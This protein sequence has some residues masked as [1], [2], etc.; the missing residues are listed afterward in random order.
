MS[1]LYYWSQH[2]LWYD[3]SIH[4]DMISAYIMIWSQHTL[5]YDL[6]IHYDMISAYIMIWSQLTLWYDLSIHY[7]MISAYIMIWS[8]LTLWYDL[9]LHYDMISAYIMIW[10]QHTLWYDLSI[11]YDMISAY[12]MIWSQ[13]TLWYDLSI[14]YDMIPAYIMIWYIYR[15]GFIRQVDPRG[16]SYDGSPSRRISW[17]GR[18]SLPCYGYD[19]WGRHLASLEKLVPYGR[20]R[21]RSIQFQLR[22]GWSQTRDHPLIQVN[23][24]QG[25]RDYIIWWR[26]LRNLHKGIP[27]GSP[28]SKLSYSQTQ[29]LWVGVHTWPKGP[30]QGGGPRPWKI[31]TSMC[32]NWMRF[33]LVSKP[34]RIHSKTLML[35]LCATMSLPL[36]IWGIRGHSVSTDVPH[37]H[38]YLRMGWKTVHETDTQTSPWA[39]IYVSR[40]S[41]PQRSD[42]ENRM[43]SESSRSMACIPSLGQSTCG[44]LFA[45]SKC[46]TKLATYMSP[47][48]KSEAWKVDSLVQSWELRSVCVGVPTNEC[49]HVCIFVCLWT[50]VR[51]LCTYC[52]HI[53]VYISMYIC[54]HVCMCVCVW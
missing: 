1:Q 51:Y 46:N 42:S 19:F 48:P 17:Q 24:D 43:E 12:I 26:N 38:Q 50:N 9:S 35:P 6:S 5:W 29:A 45:K 54:M 31:C 49:V 13:H 39:S 30:L 7:D 3:P 4:Y 47:I 2:T 25:T 23:L 53:Y 14:H 33:G 18:P 8:Q 27:L 20:L 52:V 37:G 32:W 21:I 44:Y 15:S 10:S 22:S 41:E 36:P 40:L 11:H 34:L 28:W 16:G